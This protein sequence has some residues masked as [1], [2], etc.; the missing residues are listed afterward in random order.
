MSN[1]P[2]TMPSVPAT[3]PTEGE[4]T[5]GLAGVCPLAEVAD[6]PEPLQLATERASTVTTPTRKNRFT[7]GA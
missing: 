5:T 1:V 2:P 3:T 4:L 7:A 6:R